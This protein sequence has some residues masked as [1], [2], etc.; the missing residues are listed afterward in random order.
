M[1]CHLS[2]NVSTQ[3]F[4]PREYQVE[5][6]DSAKNKNI[7]ICS[8]SSIAKTFIAVKLVQELAY[9]IRFKRGKQAVFVLDLQNVVV[10]ESHMKLL[11]DLTVVSIKECINS[12]TEWKDHSEAAVIVTTAELWMTICMEKGK[13]M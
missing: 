9:D 10:I 3:I 4:T 13:S 6:L 12:Y 2:E 11:T 8:S 5:L 7:I 1:A